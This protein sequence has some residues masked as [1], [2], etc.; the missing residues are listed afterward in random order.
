MKLVLPLV[1]MIAACRPPTVGS[2]VARPLPPHREVSIDVTP[3]A[4]RRML[5]PEGYLRAYLHWFGDLLPLEVQARARGRN[6]F[7]SWTDYLA[8]LGLPDLKLDLPRAEQSNSLMLA[9]LGR[10][11]EALCI[12]AAERD[13]HGSKTPVASRAVFAF[14][15][16]KAP[17]TA[18]EFSPRFDVLHRIFLG[19]PASLAPPRRAARYYTLYQDVSARSAKRKRGP[20]TAEESGWAAVCAALIQHPEVGLYQ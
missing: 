8:A 15:V 1:V 10:L 3:K 11:G 5:Q 13:L 4:P 14:E 2:G 18:D 9:A 19:Y 7:D 17:L 20:L 12:R 6:V 16:T